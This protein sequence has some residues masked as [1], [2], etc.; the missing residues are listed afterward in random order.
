ML[1]TRYPMLFVFPTEFFKIVKE[2]RSLKKK[3]EESYFENRK[4]FES[5]MGNVFL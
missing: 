1:S 4:K 3:I 2:R 5:G